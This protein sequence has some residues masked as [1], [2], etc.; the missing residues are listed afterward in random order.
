[1]LTINPAKRITAQEALKHPWVCVS[2]CIP[3]SIS[4]ASC[5]ILPTICKSSNREFV[6]ICP[7]LP[8]ISTICFQ[9][10]NL[11]NVQIQSFIL[12]VPQEA[13]RAN[14]PRDKCSSVCFN[15]WNITNWPS[16]MCSLYHCVK[17]VETAAGEGRREKQCTRLCVTFKTKLT[18]CSQRTLSQNS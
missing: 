9:T 18:K 16:G 14:Y 7:K 3:S 6:N 13:E 12:N 17:Q 11:W 15:R 1:M 2:T 10:C 5:L 8:N 4:H